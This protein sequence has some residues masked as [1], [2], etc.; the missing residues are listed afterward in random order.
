MDE[1][2]KLII[3]IVV[4]A[5]ILLAFTGILI[6]QFS[7]LGVGPFKGVDSL[8]TKIEVEEK[9]LQ[10][11]KA[12]LA[13]E[14]PVKQDEKKALEPL[15]EEAKQLL[16]EE[17]A[18]ERLLK[19]I[20]AK[21]ELALVDLV[22]I[23]SAKVK[24]QGGFFGGGAA[25]PFDEIVYSMNIIGSLDELALFLNYM[26]MFE[27]SGN[28]GESQKRFFE[29]KDIKIKAD[30]SGLVEGGR[31]QIALKM[32]TYMKKSAPQNTGF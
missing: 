29:V 31:H 11:M 15:A 7:V 12:R 24:A 21:A 32:S 6:Y 20:N 30:G 23:D 2:K 3:T 8:L 19:F 25:K 17:I 1:K 28:E 10:G 16:P 13:S 14:L 22:A 27:L 5:V 18:P 9:K 26:E 4:T